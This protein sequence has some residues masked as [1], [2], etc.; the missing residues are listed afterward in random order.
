MS[1]RKTIADISLLGGHPALDFVNTVDA[2]RDRWGPD[3]LA[4]Y[5]DLVVWAERVGLIDGEA[6]RRVRLAARAGP[7]EAQ[8]ALERARRLR[9]ALYNLGQ[10]EATGSRSRTEDMASLSDAILRAHGKRRIQATGGGLEWA[11]SQDADLDLVSDRVALAA[12]EL[13]VDRAVDRRRIRECPGRNCG[14]LFLDT[15]RGGRRRWCSD[16]TCGTSER[17]R[18]FRAE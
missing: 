13:L 14:W 11:W 12:C 16:K 3:F 7:G 1:S 5:D 8:A 6:A 4:T 18:R 10:A 9:A 15:S 2:W 17:V